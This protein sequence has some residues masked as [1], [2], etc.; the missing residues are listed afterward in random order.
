[1][2]LV[3]IASFKVSSTGDTGLIT[4]LYRWSNW[5]TK[6]TVSLPHSS[7]Q[8]QE[9]KP[10]CPPRTNQDVFVLLTSIS[11]MLAQY[12]TSSPLSPVW[13]PNVGAKSLGFSPLE[14]PLIYPSISSMGFFLAPRRLQSFPGEKR[15]LPLASS[16]ILPQ[17]TAPSTEVKR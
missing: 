14:M 5:G 12:P 4:P 3:I 2:Y 9:W 8:S 7:C 13:L 16:F 17:N 1:M 10:I 11:K 15:H 6:A